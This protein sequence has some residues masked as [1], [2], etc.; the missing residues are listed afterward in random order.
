MLVDIIQLKQFIFKYYAQELLM[1]STT[2]AQ[3]QPTLS[4]QLTQINA[5]MLLIKLC[6]NSC[7]E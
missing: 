5:Y 2:A 7:T 1:T 3:Q 6:L 4:A